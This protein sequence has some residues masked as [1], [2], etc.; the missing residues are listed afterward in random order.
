MQGFG[1]AKS[2]RPIERL[3]LA[4]ASF[5]LGCL[6]CLGALASSSAA[7]TVTPIFATEDTFVFSPG[8]GNTANY[9]DAASRNF[10]NL[11]SRHVAAATAHPDN[12]PANPSKGEFKAVARFYPSN[13]VAQLDAQFGVGRWRIA[14]L[15]LKLT[16]SDNV[17]GPGIFNAPGNAGQF[18]VSWLPSDGDWLQGAGYINQ[19]ASPHDPLLSPANFTNL[20]FT[21]LH[22]ILTTNPAVALDTFDFVPNGILAPATNSL[23]LTNAAFLA[24]LAGA[25]PT[26]L[27]FDA[28]DDHVAFNFT[29]HLYGDDR[30]TNE[31]SPTLFLTA[32]PLTGPLASLETN[33]GNAFLT[34]RFQRQA[35]IT[36]LTCVVEV[37]SEL[38]AGGWT[39]L[40][41][42]TN[43]AALAGPGLVNETAA[44]EAGILNVT[45]SDLEPVQTATSRFVNLRFLK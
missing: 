4:T 2:G 6:L 36:N 30:I 29:S 9:W 38:A 25:Q 3:S 15:T 34:V 18:C 22:A 11:R 14:G 10:G 17:A 5:R 16:T 41:S 39:L 42:G 32:A 27:L 23:T 44:A 7:Q 19:G 1:T 43:G 45:V 20:T 31:Y 40:A 24:A 8:P 21:S 33:A 35:G 26:S 13:A 37:A 28:A 12:D